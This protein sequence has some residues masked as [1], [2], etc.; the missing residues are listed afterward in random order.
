MSAG[1]IVTTLA[2]LLNIYNFR[3]WNNISCSEKFG[4]KLIQ[5]NTFIIN[6]SSMVRTTQPLKQRGTLQCSSNLNFKR[7]SVIAYKMLPF[8]PGIFVSCFI[9]IISDGLPN[10]VMAQFRR[11]SIHLALPSRTYLEFYC[12]PVETDSTLS[13][14]IKNGI[15]S[16]KMIF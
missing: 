4:K 2:T 7:M 5:N 15:I 1:P 10:E 6:L 12:A 13:K 11:H 14:E 16:I 3:L 8:L 9:F